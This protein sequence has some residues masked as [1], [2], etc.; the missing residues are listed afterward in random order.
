M[1]LLSIQSYQGLTTGIN[2]MGS[3]KI[4]EAII[5]HLIEAK[6]W[7]SWVYSWVCEGRGKV[8]RNMLI[9]FQSSWIKIHFQSSENRNEGCTYIDQ[10]EYKF[11][12]QMNSDWTMSIQA[13]MHNIWN[14]KIVYFSSL[15]CL[16]VYIHNGNTRGVLK[17]PYLAPSYKKIFQK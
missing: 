11:T 14:L 9:S 4:I 2:N 10:F 12:S 17:R 13:K 16:G 5:S 1:L 6:R 8:C 3:K 7:Y 15:K